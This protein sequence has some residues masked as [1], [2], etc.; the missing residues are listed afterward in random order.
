M[1]NEVAGLAASARC[2]VFTLEARDKYGSR[3]TVPAQV[4]ELIIIRQVT[5]TYSM[6]DKVRHHGLT[7]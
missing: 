7:D 6:S 2:K 4:Q 5:L 3:A 1:K